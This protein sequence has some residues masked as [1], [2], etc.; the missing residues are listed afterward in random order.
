M[1]LSTVRGHVA[2]CSGTIRQCVLVFALVLVANAIGTSKAQAQ[3][4][5]NAP[6]IFDVRRSLP[7][8]P[9][10]EVTHDFYINAGPELG[11]KK[12]SFINVV[13]PVP[14]HDP[15]QNK[16]Q[17]TL[18]IPIGKLQIIHVEKNIAVGRLQSELGDDE[19][20]TVEFEA[21]MIGD[22]VDLASV[23]ND[24]P[25]KKRVRAP[26]PKTAKAELPLPP[27]ELP[28]RSL[29]PSLNQ[30]A[31]VVPAAAPQ[32]E[33]QPIVPSTP[34]TSAETEELE[35]PVRSSPPLV[36]KPFPVAHAPDMLRLEQLESDFY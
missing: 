26:A 25:A 5:M 13:R 23:T 9:E 4:Y 20:P 24:A 21:V 30:P 6:T 12:G 31:P 28:N 11:L 36:K 8:D 10:E 2:M 34:P 22:R 14:V 19:R 35:E 29:D 3:N 1:Y 17:A 33:R 32:P 7:L 27:V 16:Q 18:N 15:I